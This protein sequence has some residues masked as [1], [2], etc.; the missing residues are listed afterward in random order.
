MNSLLYNPTTNITEFYGECNITS[1]LDPT[2][3]LTVYMKSD[4]LPQEAID[5][6]PV[7]EAENGEKFLIL[8]TKKKSPMVSLNFENFFKKSV[9]VLSVGLY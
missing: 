7:F 9:S 2:F 4:P 6:I 1:S 5:V 3:K 8:G